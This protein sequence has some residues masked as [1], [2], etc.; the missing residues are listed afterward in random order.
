L[1]RRGA[2]GDAERGRRGQQEPAGL[3]GDAPC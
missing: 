1:S 3:H 2:A